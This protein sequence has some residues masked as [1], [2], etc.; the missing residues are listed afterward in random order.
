LR[1]AKASLWVFLL[2]VAVVACNLVHELGGQDTQPLTLEP[3]PMVGETSGMRRS[4]ADVAEDEITA[5]AKDVR[6]K[7]PVVTIV[8]TKG[9]SS[10]SRAWGKQAQVLIEAMEK[11]HE[12]V[13]Q[14]N[15]ELRRVLQT[16]GS[17]DKPKKQPYGKVNGVRLTVNSKSHKNVPNAD[18]CEL[19]CSLDRACLSFSY[20]T[21]TTTCVVSNAAFTYSPEAVFYAK[22]SN[23][24]GKGSKFHMFPGIL[25]VT[26]ATAATQSA[27]RSTEVGCKLKCIQLGE[28]CRGF[29]FNAKKHL[30]SVS[31]QPI[32]YDK[33]W[34]YYEKPPRA[35]FAGHPK[36]VSNEVQWDYQRRKSAHFWKEFQYEKNKNDK[37][38]LI[39]LKERVDK[40]ADQADTLEAKLRDTESEYAT[41]KVTAEKL[42]RSGKAQ[43]HG[44]RASNKELSTAEGSLK[45]A[46]MAMTIVQDQI[47][48]RKDEIL[49]DDPEFEEKGKDFDADPM[50]VDLNEKL[51]QRRKNEQ[52]ATT[53]VFAAQQEYDDSQSYL[54]Q[55]DKRQ[56]EAV[57]RSKTLEETTKAKKTELK[58][59]AV[60]ALELQKLLAKEEELSAPPPE[61]MDPPS[62][63]STRSWDQKADEA[64]S[65]QKLFFMSPAEKRLMKKKLADKAKREEKK[66]ENESQPE[67]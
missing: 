22:A 43:A 57:T 17:P 3:G 44:L 48:K 10:G 38:K 55:N 5:L 1:M 24:A 53:K 37:R 35:H 67:L 45:E 2:W 18:S 27:V 40:V 60:K 63:D 50:I 25:S 6:E 54:R 36:D 13:T 47:Q 59:L 29:S 33:Y 16:P 46:K 58:L 61:E 23:N 34:D 9:S 31:D 8:K 7:L 49:Q 15:L 4:A 20:N 11:L 52:E 65:K 28:A 26:G 51:V 32:E 39:K 66:V 42:T 41:A 14:R 12:K 19:K 30:C 56:I 21:E 64:E 62:L